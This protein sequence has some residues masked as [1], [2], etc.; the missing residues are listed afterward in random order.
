M[1]DQSPAIF[2]LAHFRY[3]EGPNPYL[4]T[5]AIVFDF[6]VSSDV[7][8]PTWENY[9]EEIEKIFPQLKSRQFSSQADLFAQTVSLVSQLDMGLHLKEFQVIE[10]DQYQRIA[11]Q[12]L[13]YRTLRQAIDLVWDWL[14]AIAHHKDFDL[15]RGI[16]SLQA[17]FCASAYGGPT[18]Y[19]LLQ[20]AAKQGIPYFYLLEERLIQYGYG[21]YQV[22]GFSTTFDSDS[23]LDSDF[24]TQKDDCKTFL[25]NCG[26]PVPQGEVVD[27]LE[28]ALAVA[29][30]IGYPVAVKPLSGH[31]GIGVTANIQDNRGLRSAFEQ[32][33]RLS[34][35]RG[36]P[37]IVEK[38]ILGS[39]FRLLCVG[40][41]FVAGLER[42]PPFVIG[43]GQSTIA[44]LIDQEN[45]TVARQDT[46]TSPLAKIHLDSRMENYLAQQGLYLVSILK[47]EQVVYLSQVA[48]ISG[49]GV[50]V[51]VTA[52]VHPDNQQLA[53]SIAQHFRLVC[54]GVDVITKDISQSWQA[55]N[56][57]VLEINAAPG[58]SMHLN[59][60]I[61][62]SVDVPSRILEHFFPGGESCRIPIITFNR[63]EQR[64]LFQY[65]DTILSHYPHWLI[66][67]ISEQGV[68]LNHNCQNF[69]RDYNTN[70]RTLLRHAQLDCLLAEYPE[71][72]FE[73]QGTFYQGS[74]LVILEN[75]TQTEMILARDLLP[76]GSLILRQENEILVK[77]QDSQTKYQLDNQ[78]AFC[79]F[80][81]QQLSQF[82]GDW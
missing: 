78:Q 40:G 21:K 68:W 28:E 41:K 39:D 80:C 59:P 43:D 56:L 53:N 6:V 25:A 13:H 67:S 27:S 62:N 15:H 64:S 10:S 46:P 58:V 69:P 71:A 31:K 23:H 75:P 11:L 12:C 79:H 18:S 24:T 3:Y 45:A 19:A 7:V 30:T 72:I 55:G 61:G 26:F 70:I 76:G 32:A 37:I 14:E 20:A 63:L 9:L 16:R 42:R 33:T 2:N 8:S 47:P 38:H 34:Y 52:K 50:S 82:I 1:V 54:L 17:T 66:G 5:P 4:N 77:K 44:D 57:A 29:E 49:G 65:I 22:R 35:R 74:N 73:Q 81:C 36:M 51:D 60:A 48:N